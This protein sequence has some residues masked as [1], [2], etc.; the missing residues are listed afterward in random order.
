MKKNK[1]DYQYFY[2][3][4]LPHFQPENALIFITYRLAFNLPKE[5][6]S[7]L[8]EIR[9]LYDSKI[10]KI[11]EVE[12]SKLKKICNKYLFEIEDKYLDSCRN[13]PLWLQNNEVAQIVINSLRFNDRKLYNLY[14]VMIMPNHVHII[15]KP[16]KSESKP[17][18]LAKIMKDH[19]SYTAN[20]ANKLLQRNGQFWHHENY[21]HYIRDVEDYFRIKNYVLNNPVKARLVDTYEHWKYFYISE[22]SM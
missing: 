4:N 15:I 12:K 17:V 5:V 13:S 2:M 18:S 11:N 14:L 8:M 19:K 21:D 10:V 20:E 22:C 3:R 7:N 1:L 6:L 16:V 9:K